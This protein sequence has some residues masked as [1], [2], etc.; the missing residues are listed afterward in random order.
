VTAA[1]TA[2][3]REILEKRGVLSPEEIHHLASKTK[4]GVTKNDGNKASCHSDLASAEE[5][6]AIQQNLA[7]VAAE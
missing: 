5:A 4:K 7:E 1:L 2:E 6:K 3:Q